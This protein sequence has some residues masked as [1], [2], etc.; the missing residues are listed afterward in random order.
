MPARLRHAPDRR[1][2]V[3]GR[4][5]CY[6]A[7]PLLGQS[8]WSL[9]S[10]V[11]RAKSRRPCRWFCARPFCH[12]KGARPISWVSQGVAVH[13]HSAENKKVRR[14]KRERTLSPKSYSQGGTSITSSSPVSGGF[15]P[16]PRTITREVLLLFA[17]FRPVG[18]GKLG[19][20][21]VGILISYVNGVNVNG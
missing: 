16:K 3:H 17:N 4:P 11:L 2:I 21:N 20:K 1:P 9:C 6:R 18:F 12:L 7:H 19:E 8:Q 14:S 15:A 10:P 5:H 13:W